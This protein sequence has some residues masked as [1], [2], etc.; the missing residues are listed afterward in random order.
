MSA[1][2][3]APPRAPAPVPHAA[4]ALADPALADPARLAALGATGALATMRLT[5]TSAAAPAVQAAGHAVARV[6][7]VGLQLTKQAYRDDRVTPLGAADRVRPG[8]YVQYKIAATSVGTAGA[9]AVHV[10]DPLPPE[11]AYSAATPDAAGWTIAAPGGTLT[12]DLAG[13]LPVGQ[14]RY[15][16]LRARVR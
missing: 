5:A 3:R 7:R 11:L 4:P 10:S 13:G 2:L 12:V 8:E 6:V 14:S 15:L 1:S 9:V 16:W